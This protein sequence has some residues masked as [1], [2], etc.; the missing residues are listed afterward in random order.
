MAKTALKEMTNVQTTRDFLDISDLDKFSLRQILNKAK[1]LKQLQKTSGH[2]KFLEGKQ[3]AMIFEKNSTR[4]RV[5]FEVGINQLGGN[6]IFISS[7]D[8]QI[9][10][11][12]PIVDTANVLSRY[13][14]MIMIRTFSHENLQQ[15]AA[16]SS[17][18]V[19]NG[20]TDYSHP[21][22]ILADIQTI[23][24]HLG[25]IEGKII[26]WFGDFNNVCRSW[27]H[28]AESL[29]FELRISTPK[30]YIEGLTESQFVKYF[31][32]PQDAAK[33]AD[34][35]T[36]DTWVSMGDEIET[37]KKKK[38]LKPYQVNKELCKNAKENFIFLHCLPAHRGEEVTAE[39]IDGKNS[40][41]Y[42]EA[43]NRLHAQK[44]VM[45]WCCGVI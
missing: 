13:C 7:K 26:A 28:A 29:G 42:D 21:C 44:A 32:N 11:G 38:A 15:L 22:Q 23:E 20:L 8:S 6:A 3:L 35:I 19:I 45:L 24:E 37:D 9:G 31:E 40:V 41:I 17:V 5:S 2:A 1:E 10:R 33:N 4:T 12:E 39:I 18:P 34:V 43:E 27:I 36:T 30:K 25:N 16:H 14:D